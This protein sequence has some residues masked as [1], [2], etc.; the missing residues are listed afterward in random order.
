MRQIR[1]PIIRAAFSF[2]QKTAERRNDFVRPAG[3]LLK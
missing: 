1:L 2:G 3:K